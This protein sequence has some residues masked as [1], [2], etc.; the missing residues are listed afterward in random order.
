M[1]TQTAYY[2]ITMNAA[3]LNSL[4]TY[5]Q[6]L[7]L[8]QSN[9]K[10]LAEHLVEP[11]SASMVEEDETEYLTSSSAMREILEE[12]LKPYDKNDYVKIDLKDLWK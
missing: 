10:W 7:Q 12:G 5:L 2:I 11:T 8:T 1:C 9:R 4:W 3:A 6:S